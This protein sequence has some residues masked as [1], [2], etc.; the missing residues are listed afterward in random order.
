MKFDIIQEYN[1]YKM[2][3]NPEEVIGLPGIGCVEGMAC[4]KMN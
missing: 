2:F 1:K 4:M 3:V